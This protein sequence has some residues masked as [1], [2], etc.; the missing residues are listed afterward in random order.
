VIVP[1]RWLA[2]AALALTC[3]GSGGSGGSTATPVTPARPCLHLGVPAYVDAADL[4]RLGRAPAV[5]YVI[6]NPSDGP[7]VERDA[8]LAEAVAGVQLRGARVL[9][10]VHTAYG[11]RPLARLADEIDRYRRWYGIDGVFVDEVS[12][13]A[14]RL[15]YFR[16][17]AQLVRRRSGDVVALNPGVVPARGYFDLADV[18]VTFESTYERY[19][20]RWPAHLDTGRAEQWHLVLGADEA[21]MRQAVRLAA[22]RGA[23]VLDVTDRLAGGQTW[24]ALPP[25]LDAEAAAVSRQR[26]GR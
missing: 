16:Q 12:D 1:T 19:A 21:Q 10:Y 18:V 17:L 4:A 5:R 11:A 25:Y 6:L 8:D 20:E 3:C 7:D 22:R 14:D 9:G 2:A 15:P 13:T 23:T 24:N 26:C